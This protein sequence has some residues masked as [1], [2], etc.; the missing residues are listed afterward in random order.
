VP[1]WVVYVQVHTPR[2][3]QSSGTIGT[4]VDLANGGF[5]VLQHDGFWLFRT[6][7]RKLIDYQI[8]T[9]TASR[10]GFVKAASLR[11]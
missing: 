10:P 7:C 3:V 6:I 8:A 11:G 4:L 2:F 1:S 9:T 5:R